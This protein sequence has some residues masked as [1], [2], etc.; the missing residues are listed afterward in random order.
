MAYIYAQ[1][2]KATLAHIINSKKVSRE[3]IT[4]KIKVKPE[5]LEK[6]MD[7][8][9]TAFPTLNQAKEIASCLHIPFAALYMNP[10]DIKIR[11][12]PSIKNMRTLFD[13]KWSDDSSLNIA[14][15]DLLIEREFLFTMRSELNIPASSLSL[16]TLQG[17]DVI[18]WAN[19]IRAI[20]DI[21][22]DKQFKCPSLR[23]FYLYLRDQIEK[24]GIFVHCFTDVP[25]EVARGLAIYDT[26]MP[27]IGV[28]EDDRPP[29]KSFTII[30]E[31][32]HLLKRESSL[33]NEMLNSFATQQE[34][35]FCNAVAGE[36]LVPKRDL[37]LVLQN[38]HY[39]KPY[40]LVNIRKIADHFSVSREV[41]IRR[42]LDTDH[43]DEVEYHT[44]A[45]EIHRQIERDKEEQRIARKEGRGKT[46]VQQPSRLAID[47][48]SQAV[49]TA[50]FQGYCE[51][52]YSKRDIANHV[53]IDQKHIDKFLM[54]V[55][56]WS[57]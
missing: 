34:E 50:L 7:L 54:E 43:I 15:V 44:Y 2:N 35:V 36:V 53:G 40:D 14:I 18:H 45:D 19:E 33:C 27:I 3:Y 23:Q 47:R 56:E 46:I 6:W 49:C 8:S 30:H 20:F 16:P 12:I 26:E 5:K 55:A 24:S 51:N 17:N 11:E 9:D 42:L 13:E 52:I 25:L 4:T 29:A 28:N 38:G 31:L 37:E 21:K 1:I 41:I 10:Q 22:L 57:N 32:V 48:T 39:S